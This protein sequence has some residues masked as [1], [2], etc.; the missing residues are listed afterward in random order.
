MVVSAALVDGEG[1]PVPL[2]DEPTVGT[3]VEDRRRGVGGSVDEALTEMPPTP[4]GKIQHISNHNPNMIAATLTLSPLPMLI[5]LLIIM[6]TSTAFFLPRPPPMDHEYTVLNAAVPDGQRPLSA[7]SS[8]TI[9]VLEIQDVDGWLYT[10]SISVGEPPLMYRALIDTCWSD[11]FLP[12]VR[13]LQRYRPEYCA[14]HPLYNSTASLTYK[15]VDGREV[16]VARGGFYT[17]GNAAMERLQLG[18]LQIHD[19]TFEE[20]YRFRPTYVMDDTIYDTVLGLSR[21]TVRSIDSDL[22]AASPLQNLMSSN[23]L[24]RNVFSLS[25]PRIAKERGRLTLG[26]VD[27][28]IDESFVDATALPL[29]TLRNDSSPDNAGGWEVD[30]VRLTFGSGSGAIHCPLPSHVAIFSTELPVL[31]L[32]G[33]FAREVLTRVGASNYDGT[34]D[35]DRVFDLP[36]ITIS[37]QGRGGL[38]HDFVMTP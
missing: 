27:R 4:G 28:D 10:V 33:D 15:R 3:P 38:I 35:C 25:L 19:Q 24:E 22:Q 14:P 34:V 12:S 30:A 16:A 36:N 7:S 21:E 31:E 8:S 23:R 29:S 13:C 20:A 9:T 37:L 32:P 17:R 6:S 2:T 26:G 11:L 18:S 5:L 1:A